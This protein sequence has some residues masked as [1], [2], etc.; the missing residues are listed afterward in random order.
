M[1]RWYDEKYE[2]MEPYEKESMMKL[3]GLANT[4]AADVNAK[5]SFVYWDDIKKVVNDLKKNYHLEDDH[6]DFILSEFEQQLHVV[7]EK[8]HVE[9]ELTDAEQRL[10][11]TLTLVPGKQHSNF[12][13]MLV[14]N[15]ISDFGP[16]KDDIG[17]WVKELLAGDGMDDSL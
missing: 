8:H 6:A 17:D 11:L 14:Q 9:R 12:R 2:S 10:I 1:N 15:Y 4:Y 16:I 5:R 13:A 3:W 7:P